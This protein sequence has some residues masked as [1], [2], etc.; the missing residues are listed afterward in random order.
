[1]N[2]IDIMAC[3]RKTA[4]FY[5]GL[6]KP[7]C[8]NYG[9]TLIEAHIIAFLHNNPG[10]DTASDICEYRML[11]K[12]NVSVAVDGLIGRGWLSRKTDSIDRRV[13]HLELTDD[14]ANVIAALTIA[15]QSYFDRVLDGL[16]SEER[17]SLGRLMDRISQNLSQ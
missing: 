11:P 8:T 10:M 4:K 7:V 13:I 14:A 2:P 17:D 5:D 15:Q 9:I 3:M 12:S 6:I 16:S 1:M